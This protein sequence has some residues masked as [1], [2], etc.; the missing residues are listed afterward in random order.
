MC[1]DIIYLLKGVDK[2]MNIKKCMTGCLLATLLTSSILPASAG[3]EPDLISEPTA[4]MGV[5]EEETLQLSW[6]VSQTTFEYVCGFLFHGRP[7][8]SIPKRIRDSVI[9]TMGVH[10]R[11]KDFRIMELPS[12]DSPIQAFNALPFFVF[13][14]ISAAFI[15]RRIIENI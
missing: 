11:Q 4:E 14:G 1:S 9:Y 8:D 6:S 2:S 15:S 10:D 5:Q 7:W 3:K 12:L 13:R